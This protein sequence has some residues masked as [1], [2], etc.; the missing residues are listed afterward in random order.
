MNS[1]RL[2]QWCRSTSFATTRWSVVLAAADRASPGARAALSTLCET[3]WYPLYAF[4]R[5]R[6][7]SAEDA[8]DSTQEFFARL[9]EKESL[10]HVHPDKGR[11]RSFLLTSFKN[12]M[13]DER[14][15]ARAKKRGGGQIPVS[16]DLETAEG[17][18][19][20]EPAAALTPDKIFERRWAMTLLDRAVERLREEHARANKER[21]FE[22]LKDYLP[23]GGGS[24]PYARAA[25]DLDISEIAV[26]VAVH[27]LRRRFRAH[28]L[29]EI[30]QTLGHYDDLGAEVRHLLSVMEG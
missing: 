3:Y 10:R 27:R 15:R 23:G 2:T 19:S 22:R 26:K 30:A 16:I 6:G 20:N 1:S 28:L 9:L 12:F 5:R 7:M 11:F 21:I 17:R 13:E 4:A 8:Q 18:Y 14:A 24:V 29:D 25:R